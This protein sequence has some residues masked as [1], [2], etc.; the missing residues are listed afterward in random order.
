MT[1]SDCSHDI[2]E[3]GCTSTTERTRVV[4][5]NALPLFA[6]NGLLREENDTALQLAGRY[7]RSKIDT[8]IVVERYII[9]L[10]FPALIVHPA[11]EFCA[12]IRVYIVFGQASRMHAWR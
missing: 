6:W 8:S 3:P 1:Q 2:A 12:G 7:S 5:P 9:V 4:D 10:R 11:C